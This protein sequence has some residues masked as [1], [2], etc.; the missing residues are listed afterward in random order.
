[1]TEAGVAAPTTADFPTPPSSPTHNL[2][3]PRLV[4]F[5]QVFKQGFFKQ[6]FRCVD[7]AQSEG[8]IETTLV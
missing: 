3:K 2:Q 7:L 5:K 8:L 1:M 4:F 6:G